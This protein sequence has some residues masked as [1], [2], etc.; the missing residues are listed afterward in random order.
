M[1]ILTAYLTGKI[2]MF[3]FDTEEE[4]REAFYNVSGNKIISRVV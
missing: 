4:V 2:K 3:E 1:W